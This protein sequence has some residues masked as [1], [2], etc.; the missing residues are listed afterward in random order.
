MKDYNSV[1]FQKA[2]AWHLSLLRWTFKLFNPTNLTAY[3][4]RAPK[5]CKQSYPF[6]QILR[7]SPENYRDLGLQAFSRWFFAGFPK[8][9]QKPQAE[10]LG[11]GGS[12]AG[13]TFPVR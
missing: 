6:P 13:E 10:T 7:R 9:P 3:V 1:L 8:A 2:S 12:T 4:N 5:Y 11:E